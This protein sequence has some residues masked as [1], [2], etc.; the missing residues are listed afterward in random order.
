MTVIVGLLF[1]RAS[2]IKELPEKIHS[3]SFKIVGHKDTASQFKNMPAETIKLYNSR[4]EAL[5]N[6]GK[7]IEKLRMVMSPY[8]YFPKVSA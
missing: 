6:V 3:D 5:E 2:G 1:D 8:L 7:S 4:R